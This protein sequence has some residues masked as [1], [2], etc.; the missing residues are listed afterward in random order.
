MLE[1]WDA[2]V[3]LDVVASGDG[4]L[5]V[6][7]LVDGRGSVFASKVT[8]RDPTPVRVRATRGSAALL[9]FR[10]ETSERAGH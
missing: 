8:G 7:V 9:G 5:E 4:A 10:G 3:L 2:P 1:L 6:E